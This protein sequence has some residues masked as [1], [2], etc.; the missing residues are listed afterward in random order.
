[1]HDISESVM[2]TVAGFGK[3]VRPITV[4]RG[5]VTARVASIAGAARS[6]TPYLEIARLRRS[7]E[8]PPAM[9]S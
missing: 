6:P 2:V 7:R 8:I 5:T 9:V 1:M 4:S 3:T